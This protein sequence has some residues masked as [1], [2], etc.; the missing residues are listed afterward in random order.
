MGLSSVTQITAG[1]GT[2]CARFDDGSVSCWGANYGGTIPLDPPRYDYEPHDPTPAS[3][4]GVARVDV[5]ARGAVFATKTSGEL[6][7]WG[8]NTEDQLARAS[9]SAKFLGPGPTDLTATCDPAGPGGCTKVVRAG[10]ASSPMGNEGSISFAIA[11]DG[12]MYIWGSS[13]E[14]VAYPGAVPIVVDGLANVGS[15]AAT[16]SHL[17]AVADGRLYCWGPDGMAACT[18][19]ADAARKPLEIRT[20][21]KARPQQVAVSHR[22]TC[23]R[24]N[25]GTIQ[26]CGADDKGQLGVADL[27]AGKP[28]ARTLVET[29]GLAGRAVSVAV[30][31]STTCALLQGGTVQC[32][33]NN[34]NG[35]LGGGATDEERHPIPATV[36][37]E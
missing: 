23:V 10:G 30:A 18:G 17:C 37:F 4:S 9:E 31:V 7:A 3:I 34:T 35:E 27:D 32:W 21:G 11:T 6:W 26:C 13:H 29:Q 20:L 14:M 28:F 25:D 1:D 15:A 8:A 19:V 24:M 5:A 16:T 36:S 2:T 22:H 33:G 12:R